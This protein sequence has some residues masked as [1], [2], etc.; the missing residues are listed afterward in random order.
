MQ[1]NETAVRITHLPT[2]IVVQCQNERS[3]AQNRETAMRIL[4]ARL[5]QKQ[6]EELQAQIDELKGEHVDAGWGNQ[7]RSY[8]L[9]PYQMVKDH[10][11]DR[12]TGNVQAVLDGDLD[13]FM[14]AFLRKRIGQ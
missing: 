12:E 4:K 14:E 2:E 9:H 6:E 3:Q 10:R 13:E 7:I 11:T 1:K 5:I 8:V